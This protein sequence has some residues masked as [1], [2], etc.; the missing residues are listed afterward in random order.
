MKLTLKCDSGYEVTVFGSDA[1]EMAKK[2]RNMAYRA[3]GRES[4][5]GRVTPSLEA[6]AFAAGVSL[7][8]G[9]AAMIDTGW[10]V[11][12]RYGNE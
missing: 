3:E 11:Y 6:V 1:P 4:G 7:C 8:Q 12:A 2:A 10:E 5:H 9:R